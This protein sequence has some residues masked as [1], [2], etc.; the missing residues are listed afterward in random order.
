MDP[1]VPLRVPVGKTL[2][3]GI[4]GPLRQAARVAEKREV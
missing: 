4:V 2:E 3:H 1:I